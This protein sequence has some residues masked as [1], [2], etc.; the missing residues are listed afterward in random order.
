MSETVVQVYTFC[1]D[2]QRVATPKNLVLKWVVLVAKGIVDTAQGVPIL[3]KTG[4]LSSTCTSPSKRAK[5]SSCVTS[6]QLWFGCES[7]GPQ[8]DTPDA[9]KLNEALQLK[10]GILHRH[11]DAMKMNQKSQNKHWTETFQLS[12]KYQDVKPTFSDS[13]EKK[14]QFETVTWVKLT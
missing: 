6:P 9:V 1:A 11:Y 12:E 14:S 10:E 7:K 8:T 13:G 3:I 4:I 5:V 2:I